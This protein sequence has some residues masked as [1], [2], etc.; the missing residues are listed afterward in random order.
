MVLLVHLIRYTSFDLIDS[1]PFG[2]VTVIVVGAV[3][4]T[5]LKRLSL[6]SEI[7]VGLVI[8]ET[9][10]RQVGEMRLSGGVHGKM[11]LFSVLSTI[12]IQF[13]LPSLLN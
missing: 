11:P 13:K 2:A 9:F 7:V 5:I 10:T 4:G 1:P 12:V 8:S 6:I 3:F